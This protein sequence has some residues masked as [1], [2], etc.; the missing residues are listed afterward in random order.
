M[1]EDD[2]FVDAPEPPTPDEFEPEYPDSMRLPGAIIIA[3]EDPE[4]GTLGV[5][6]LWESGNRR[7]DVIKLVIKNVFKATGV[8]LSRRWLKRHGYWPDL[9]H[10]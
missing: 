3:Y 8:K 5:K 10:T 7:S 6:V 2:G 1:T 9:N 4:H